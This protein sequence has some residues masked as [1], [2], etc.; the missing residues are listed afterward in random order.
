[1]GGAPQVAMRVA[2]QIWQIV[3]ASQTLQVFCLA[4]RKKAQYVVVDAI[5]SIEKEKSI[6]NKFSKYVE[7]GKWGCVMTK[8]MLESLVHTWFIR[9]TSLNCCQIFA[10]SKFNPTK[11]FL[12]FKQ[13]EN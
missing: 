6:N 13:L 12:A 9:K 4:L 8:P 5:K 1:M 10:N 7:F 3:F 2:S 11:R